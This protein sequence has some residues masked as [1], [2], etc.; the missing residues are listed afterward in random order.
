MTTIIQCEFTCA[1]QDKHSAS[2]DKQDEAE[3]ESVWFPVKV[4]LSVNNC[5]G[6]CD[7]E[8]LR[9]EAPMECIIVNDST[10]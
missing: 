6:L 9:T 1:S 5:W 2:L 10:I 4:N 3:E 7:C 8:V